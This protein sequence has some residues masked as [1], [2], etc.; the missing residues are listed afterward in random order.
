MPSRW[1]GDD[2]GYGVAA[3]RALIPGASELVTA[4]GEPAWV[5]EEPDAHLLPHVERWCQDDV[6]LALRRAR[7]D[8]DNTFIL[9]LEWRADS[10]GIGQARAAVFS[11]VGSFAESAT[12]VRQ[13]RGDT[14][15]G[16]S[17]SSLSV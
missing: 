16:G 10:A 3:A 6:R 13:R 8:D 11:L 5:A 7:I 17:T 4:F 1:D 2:R 15:S 12:Y 9:D 14:E